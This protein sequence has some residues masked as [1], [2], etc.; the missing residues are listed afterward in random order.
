[1]LAQTLQPRCDLAATDYIATD[2]RPMKPKYAH[3][4]KRIR[5]A[6]QSATGC[7]SV[8]DR[9]PISRIA[10]DVRSVSD[11][12]TSRRFVADQSPTVR[13]LYT[14]MHCTSCR[15][16]LNALYMVN[17]FNMRCHIKC[18]YCVY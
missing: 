12:M 10:I 2:P 1:M 13:C 5:I 8:G 7:R 17:I 14:K 11:L 3:I 4:W 15:K 9:S 6:D 18:S 16:S